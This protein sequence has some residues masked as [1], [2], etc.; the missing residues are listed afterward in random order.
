MNRKSRAAANAQVQSPSSPKSPQR[1]SVPALMATTSPTP[2]VGSASQPDAQP[3]IQQQPP[4]LSPHAA[5]THSVHR[6]QVPEQP[7]PSRGVNES[8]VPHVP[9]RTL[10]PLRQPSHQLTPKQ[11]AQPPPQQQP[12]QLASPSPNRVHFSGALP[13]APTSS[14]PTPNG[15]PPHPNSLHVE[16]SGSPLLPFGGQPALG[17]SFVEHP[18]QQP[19]FPQ[20]QL[21]LVPETE[22]L[23]AIARLRREVCCVSP[24]PCPAGPLPRGSQWS[25]RY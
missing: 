10:P 16:H 17:Q 15:P 2:R 3:Q 12:M 11:G 7:P 23:H 13:S 19:L 24:S 22:F 25:L 8:A 4:V 18:Q 5:H 14:G 6:V 21:R 1:L 9:D 20:V